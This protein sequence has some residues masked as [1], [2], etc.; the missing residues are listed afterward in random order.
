MEW[1]V[2]ARA[3]RQS[4]QWLNEPVETASSLQPPAFRLPSSVFPL[5]FPASRSPPVA[6]CL[7]L[8]FGFELALRVGDA[9]DSSVLCVHCDLGVRTV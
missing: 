2:V 8:C 7:S 5:W 1:D 4:Y 3:E 9:L 6:R